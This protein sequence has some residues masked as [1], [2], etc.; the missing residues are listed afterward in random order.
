M[1][2]FTRDIQTFDDLYVHQLQDI[3]YAE[4]QITKALP[5]MIEK[6]TAPELKNAFESHLR[7]TEGQIE[8]LERVFGQSDWR[9]RARPA[10]RSKASSRKPTRSPARSPTRKCSTQRWSPPASPSSIM[11]SRAT[12]R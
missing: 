2:L 1:G 7:E 9:S 10:R 8:R 6:A 12:A 5:E 4:H 11:R 3:Y